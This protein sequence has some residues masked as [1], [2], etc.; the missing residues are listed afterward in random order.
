M[1]PKVVLEISGGVLQDV[2]SDTEMDIL[3]IDH[4]NIQAGDKPHFMYIGAASKEEKLDLH[5][6]KA[7]HESNR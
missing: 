1:K 5:E 7:K 3:V 4:D 2:R 6:E